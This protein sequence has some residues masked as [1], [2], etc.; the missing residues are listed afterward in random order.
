MLI[1]DGSLGD[2]SS[3]ENEVVLQG[4]IQPRYR[5]AI[6][7]A[8]LS[9]LFEGP[10]DTPASTRVAPAFFLFWV[11]ALLT[12]NRA[13]SGAALLTRIVVSAMTIWS[14]FRSVCLRTK[15]PLTLTLV[16]PITVKTSC[17]LASLISPMDKGS[18]G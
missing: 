15:L 7:A 10:G 6:I 18:S 5:I 8:Q 4:E 2:A 12:T 11:A 14:S 9:H 17:P 13:S 3:V 16:A 1:E